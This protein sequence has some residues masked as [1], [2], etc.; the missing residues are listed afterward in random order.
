MLA[1]MKFREDRGH[2]LRLIEEAEKTSKGIVVND[3]RLCD[4]SHP[5][6]N[7][8]LGHVIYTGAKS[9]TG[10]SNRAIDLDLFLCPAF[11]PK[12]HFATIEVRI[13]A[14]FLSYRGNIAVRK[15]ALW[16]TDIYTD[17][18]DVVAMIIHSGHYRPVD[19]PDP[20]PENPDAQSVKQAAMAHNSPLKDVALSSITIKSVISSHIIPVIARADPDTSSST[21]LVP[22]HDLYVTLRILPRL[23]KYSGSTRYGLDSKGWGAS[24]DGESVQVIRVEKVQR[25]AVA[26]KGRKAFVKGQDPSPEMARSVI[27]TPLGQSLR[28]LVQRPNGYAVLDSAEKPLYEGIPSLD[29]SDSGIH[30]DT[31]YGITLGIE[32]IQWEP[33]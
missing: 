4:S 17:D 11:T 3:S 15:S 6:Y 13:P 1:K 16:G 8:S 7:L 26:R 23:I 5:N 24:H 19:A 18:S 25:G 22:D 33:K 9:R 32:G 2:V 27:V 12:D 10:H 21:I 20:F 28:F 14:E 30:I 29:F 31:P